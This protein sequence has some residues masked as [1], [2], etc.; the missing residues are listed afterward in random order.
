[1]KVLVTGSSGLIG[2]ALVPALRGAGH[3]VV[4]LVREPPGPDAARWNPDDG[5]LD[6]SALDGVDG[7][8]HLA[9]ENI[10][11]GRWTAK[12]KA[13]IRNSRVR[14]TALLARA[15]RERDTKPKVFLSGSAVGFY[16]DRGAELLDETSARGLG[17]LADVCAEW[18]AA[19]RLAADAG[20]RVVNLRTG[21]VLSREGGALRKM[22][23]PFRVGLGG[24]VGSGTQYMS[25]IAIDDLVGAL[26]Y[27]L[28][29]DSVT[30]AVNL[31]APTAVTNREFT[32]A[33]GRALR[34]PTLFKVPAFALRLALGE[35]A[36]EMLLAS[37][38]AQPARLAA[39]GYRFRYPDLEAAL[40]HVLRDA[41]RSGGG[42][43]ALL[44]S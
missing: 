41:G 39:S 30:G 31:V 44:L 3:S 38:R 22:L 4:R 5:S 27:L 2:S 37:I 19:A 12:Q 7:V 29:T 24:P 21:I 11:A 36:D 32:T 34:R 10:A 42:A 28:V 25:W 26:L 8:V 15:M 6:R 35:M 16:G 43:R 9:G 23:P 20:V 33:L 18:E 13:R 14:G 40:R 1:M 17:F